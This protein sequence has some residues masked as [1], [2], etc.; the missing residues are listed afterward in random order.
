MAQDQTSKFC[1]RCNK[2]TLHARPGTNHLAHALVTLFLCGFWLPVWILASIRIGGWRCQTCGYSGNLLARLAL[3][4]V[5]IVC[6]VIFFAGILKVTSNQT[7]R[8]QSTANVSIQTKPNPQ[9]A[10][11]DLSSEPKHYQKVRNQGKFQLVWIDPQYKYDPNVYEQAIVE[12]GGNDDFCMI[13]FWDN[14]DR[15]PP[16]IPMSD[17]QVEAQVAQYERNRN[18][19]NEQFFYLRNGDMI[20]PFGNRPSTTPIPKKTTLT[21]STEPVPEPKATHAEFRVWTNSTGKFKTEA[22]FSGIAFGKAT[23]TKRDGSSV[24]VPLDKLSEED[25][26]WIE[27]WKIS[28]RP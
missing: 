16:S 12:L 20:E 24:Q 19:G 27:E 17:E 28:K 2:H 9:Q 6:L 15:I 26:K 22:K 13:G 8:Y 18:T 3:P 10:K 1:R 23:L 11:T 25:Q 14:R 4:V 7:N 5:C 21:P